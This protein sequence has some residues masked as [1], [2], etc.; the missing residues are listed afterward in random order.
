VFIRKRSCEVLARIEQSKGAFYLAVR[1]FIPANL[2]AIKARA[3]AV[4]LI[5]DLPPAL[6]QA[7]AS[8]RIN[9]PKCSCKSSNSYKVLVRML[10]SGRSFFS[11][12]LLNNL[13]EDL[14]NPSKKSDS[15]IP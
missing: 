15:R 3:Q 1:R 9:A 13:G 10:K 11:P 7:S 5:V 2:G 6:S 14:S 12:I 4:D 8:V